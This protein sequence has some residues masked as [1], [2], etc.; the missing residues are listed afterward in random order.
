M[1]DFV[2]VRI[3][4]PDWE[5]FLKNPLLDFKQ[6]VSIVTG[7]PSGNMIAEY[8]GLKFTRYV[9]GIMIMEGSLH[10]YK[11]FG[12]HNYDDFNRLEIKNVIDD[13]KGKFNL[14][15][16]KCT[17]VNLEVG[18]NV[19]PVI[20]SKELL[21]YLYM[22]HRTEFRYEDIKNG[23]LKRA[24]YEDY[25]LKAYDKAQQYKLDKE[26]FRFEIRLLRNRKIRR[27]GLQTFD[28]LHNPDHLLVLCRCLQKSWMEILYWDRKLEPWLSTNRFFNDK[29]MSLSNANYW[30]SLA[31]DKNIHRNRYSKEYRSVQKWQD[32][33]SDRTQ[34]LMEGLLVRKLI[35][36][37]N[38]PKVQL[39][40]II[41]GGERTIQNEIYDDDDW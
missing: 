32:I 4:D 35:T 22:H 3:E 15:T 1:I 27:Y 24:S 33:I 2:K 37:L 20:P 10:K 8:Q 6:S 39:P 11:N 29:L 40:P 38:H 23:N 25:Q 34:V 19:I 14:G 5:A 31:Q 30:S 21:R 36:L 41:E 18:A 16:C 12:K 17:L 7:E 9:S 28:D 26:L 13:I